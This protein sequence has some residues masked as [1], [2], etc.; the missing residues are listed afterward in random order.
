MF[1]LHISEEGGLGS[2]EAILQFLLQAAVPTTHAAV[3]RHLAR[4]PARHRA[5]VTGGAPEAA[6]GGGE[7]HGA[8]SQPRS[9]LGWGVLSPG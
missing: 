1:A 6:E 9:G 5:R 2:E 4:G 8:S 7:I 3:H